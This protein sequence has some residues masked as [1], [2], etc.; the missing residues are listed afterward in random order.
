LVSRLELVV[1]AVF[2]DTRTRSLVGTPRWNSRAGG[3]CMYVLLVILLA[4]LVLA[5]L[6][7]GIGYYRRGGSNTTII[8]DR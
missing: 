5:L 2:E 4:V 8:E 6:L 7:G 1:D 3:V